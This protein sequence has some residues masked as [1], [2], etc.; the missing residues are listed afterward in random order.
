MRNS[1]SLPRDGPVR[2]E[3]AHWNHSVR[4]VCRGGGASCCPGGSLSTEHTLANGL[5]GVRLPFQR[6]SPGP[7]PQAPSFASVPCHL[8]L[9]TLSPCHFLSVLGEGTFVHLPSCSLLSTYW[10]LAQVFVKNRKEWRTC[11]SQ[12][13]QIQAPGGRGE[14]WYRQANFYRTLR[15]PLRH[16]PLSQEG[17]EVAAL[18][19]FPGAGRTK[20]SS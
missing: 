8:S 4:R 9:A 7:S 14:D 18:G 11:T 19:L 2:C 1:G 5:T 12:G 13:P 15:Q 16:L 20:S 17:C 3:R 6:A 10:S